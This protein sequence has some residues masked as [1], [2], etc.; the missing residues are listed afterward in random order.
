M[1]RLV[2]FTFDSAAAAGQT[3]SALQ[4]FEKRKAISLDD[5][6]V[7]ARDAAGQLTRRHDRD[8]TIIIG[9]IAGGVVG[10]LL[11]FMFPVI[12]VLF[13]AAA[14]ALFGKLLLSNDKVDREAI[15]DTEAALPPG[16][17][18]LLLLIR[19]GDIVT[20]M[21]TLRVPGMQVYQTT[22]AR[23]TEARL[24]QMVQSSNS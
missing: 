1:C 15:A 5:A 13:G 8:N 3:R 20:I 14:G 22:L 2:V 24:R 6:V 9:A 16:G 17:S 11:M 18:A 21:S 12:S 4:D 23:E 7:L 19:A 10:L